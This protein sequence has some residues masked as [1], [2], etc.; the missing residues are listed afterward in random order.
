ML[1][2][3][4][5]DYQRILDWINKKCV[6]YVELKDFILV[7]SWIPVISKD[8]LPSHYT[9]GRSFEFNPSWRKAKQKD[10]DA[11][12]WGNPFAMAKS[13]LMPDKTVIF[14]HWH[15]STGWAESEGRSEFGDD[16]KFDPYYGDGF[17]GIDACTAHSGKCNVIVIEEDSNNGDN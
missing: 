17:I 2:E 10:W 3:K 6:N 5:E 4:R 12:T 9:R 7:H 16:A 11:A 13:G 8:G 15:C 1:K 14:G